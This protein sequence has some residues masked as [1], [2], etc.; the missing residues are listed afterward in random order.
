M[1]TS[2]PA[3]LLTWKCDHV[4][5]L[6]TTYE[7]LFIVFQQNSRNSPSFLP[8]EPCRSLFFFFFGTIFIP[9]I[10]ESSHLPGAPGSLTFRPTTSRIY[11]P[12]CGNLPSLV[13]FSP[14][15]WY[16]LLS[17]VQITDIARPGLGAP[18]W[19]LHILLHATLHVI[20]LLNPLFCW[21]DTKLHEDTCHVCTCAVLLTQVRTVP[22][23][24][25][26]LTSIYLNRK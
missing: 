23:I 18:T 21:Q 4:T 25:G 26:H 3:H 2:Q 17:K 12:L 9:P 1:S 20:A 22:G 7:W 19:I 24:L 5:S 16:V 11:F 13:S 15:M 8:L 6:C 14:F 10:P